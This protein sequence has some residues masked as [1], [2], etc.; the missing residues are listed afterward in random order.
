MF[1]PDTVAFEFCGVTIWHHD[2]CTDGTDDSCGWSRPKLSKKEN[3]YAD[4]L[5]DNE[6]DNLRLFFGVQQIRVV[7]DE[8]FFEDVTHND[9]KRYIKCIASNFKRLNRKWWQHP[10]WHFWHWIIQ[11]HWGFIRFSFG[12]KFDNKSISEAIEW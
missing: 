6:H 9:M 4:R 11:V 10:R 8:S 1:D 2:P 12:R 5:I 3:L 7:G